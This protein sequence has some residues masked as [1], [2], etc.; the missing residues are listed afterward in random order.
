MNTHMLL[1]ERLDDAT[2]DGDSKNEDTKTETP[3]VF[4][5]PGITSS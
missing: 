3:C 2:C 5:F 4:V 1:G